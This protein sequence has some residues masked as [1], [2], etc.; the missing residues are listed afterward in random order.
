[1]TLRMQGIGTIELDPSASSYSIDEIQTYG[2]VTTEVEN[3]DPSVSLFLFGSGYA[4]GD[5]WRLRN[6]LFMEIHTSRR[7]V[8][9]ITYLTVQE[10][11]LGLSFEE[12]V[13]DLMTSLSDYCQSLEARE[14][15]LAPDAE[16]DLALLRDLIERN[17]TD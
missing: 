13:K 7:D 8:L 3:P 12:A 4:W 14:D 11:G 17:A 10:Y 16:E 9:A 2:S 15:R 6:P 5:G 1:M